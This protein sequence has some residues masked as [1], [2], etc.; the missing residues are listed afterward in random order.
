[1]NTTTYRNVG[2]GFNGTNVTTEVEDNSIPTWAIA[3]G[4]G[5][6]AVPL[7][8]GG[9]IGAVGAFGAIGIGFVEQALFGAVVGSAVAKSLESGKQDTASTSTTLKQELASVQSEQMGMAAYQAT[10]AQV[11]SRVHNCKVRTYK[12][13]EITGLRQGHL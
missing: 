12:P 10:E 13:D 3:A 2:V 6:L 9:S 11:A 1:M 8:I 7:A 5:A 4:V